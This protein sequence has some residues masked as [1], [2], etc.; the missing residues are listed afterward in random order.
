MLGKKRKRRSDAT[1]STDEMDSALKRFIEISEENDAK[2][3]AEEAVREDQRR[4]EEREHEGR[5]ISMM[6][7]FVHNIVQATSRPPVHPQPI[8]A[9]SY[10][11][12]FTSSPNFYNFPM[13]DGDPEHIESDGRDIQ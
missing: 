4:K 7:S 12:P 5:L 3:R 13:E 8:P 2:R 11:P 1:G 9:T 10:P 6:C